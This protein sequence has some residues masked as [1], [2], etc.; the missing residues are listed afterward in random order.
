MAGDK[1]IHLTFF[2]V[3]KEVIMDFDEEKIQ[4]IVYNL[5]S[6]AIKF[7]KKNGKVTLH[8]AKKMDVADEQ[9]YIKVMDTGIGISVDKLP[10]IFDRF[11]QIDD[12]ST[13]K[14]EGTGIGLALSK[15][16][17]EMMKGNIYVES[18]PFE[19]TVFH[20]LLPISRNSIAGNFVVNTVLTRGV[21]KITTLKEGPTAENVMARIAGSPI[22]LVIDDNPDVI[23]YI[24]SLLD[25]FVVYTAGNGQKGIDKAFVLV[26]DIIISDVM[27]PEKN[28]FE[29]CEALKKDERT[30]HI[31]IIL[32][33]ARATQEDRVEGLGYGADAYLA[34]PF[35]KE[36]LKI[37][38]SHLI[39]I[40]KKLQKKYAN[41]VK[42]GAQDNV[43]ISS[44]GPEELFLQKLKEAVES[45]LDD[46]EFGP[47][48]LFESV[49]MG[50]M[51]VYRKLKALTG[52][53]PSQFIRSIRLKNGMNLL[54]TTEMN[55]SEIAYQVGFSD[56]NYFSR[57]FQIEFKI[58]PSDFRK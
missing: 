12:S 9:L 32:L 29:V 18:T 46:T 48:Q 15:E 35:H 26:P 27:M 52:K 16:L 33:T 23:T 2:S 22:I 25:K 41:L 38:I 11:Y 36:E 24:Q 31:P 53:T 42:E 47:A 13:R 54:Q 50:Q 45:N 28:G 49:G 34:K 7:T 37:R 44:P 58:N 43:P 5:L 4:Q 51:Q 56:P 10:H 14:D 21:E 20:I 17:V 8:V 30:S 55:I 57:T 19:G 6:N 3:E 39:S 40:R 1:H